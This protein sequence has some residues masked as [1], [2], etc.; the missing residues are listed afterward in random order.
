M[1][2][3]H[4]NLMRVFHS[5]SFMKVHPV[6]IYLSPLQDSDCQ[7]KTPL[8]EIKEKSS[9]WLL[10][11]PLRKSRHSAMALFLNYF[12]ELQVQ[13]FELGH[14][15][16]GF[17]TSM[18]LTHFCCV[19]FLPYTKKHFLAILFIGNILK[20]YNV[21]LAERLQNRGRMKIMSFH[22]ARDHKPLAL[23][24]TFSW[25]LTFRQEWRHRIRPRNLILSVSYV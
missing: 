2:Y 24:H 20:F 6:H 14:G 23:T 12:G 22:P 19:H 7:A 10:H 8:I 21:W 9:L 1:D 4:F 16:R 18:F 17:Y 3:P 13:A 15:N 5:G 11:P 25:F